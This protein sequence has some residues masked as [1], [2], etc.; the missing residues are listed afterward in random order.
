MQDAPD[1][2]EVQGVTTHPLF[3]GQILEF[4]DFVYI[5]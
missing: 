1:V 4:I 3:Q 5:L 2:L